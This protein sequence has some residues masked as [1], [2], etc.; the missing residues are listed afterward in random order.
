ML[1]CSSC[2]GLTPRTSCALM[3]LHCDAPLAPPP[4]RGGNLLRILVANAGCVLLAAC[5]GPAGR[6]RMAQHPT[7][8]DRD[9]DGSPADQDCDDNDRNRYPGAA[10]VVGD[11]FDQNCDGVDGWRDPSLT[12]AEPPP[13]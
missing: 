12:V 4:S 8:V 3:C 2:G 5:Y 13:P 9:G 10:D 7:A 1:T 6:Y 11:D